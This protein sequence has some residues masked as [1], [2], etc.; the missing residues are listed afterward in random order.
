THRQLQYPGA[1]AGPPWPGLPAERAATSGQP[2]PALRP[3]AER[4]EGG[5]VAEV[6]RQIVFDSRDDLIRMISTDRCGSGINTAYA[7]RDHVPSRPSN[8]R[9]VRTMVS[10]TQ[11]KEDRFCGRES[12]RLAAVTWFHWGRHSGRLPLSLRSRSVPA[13]WPTGL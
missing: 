4:R 9:W 10:H 2:E 8:G 13:T 3:G 5:R 6:Q 1:T 11:R 7:E 12:R